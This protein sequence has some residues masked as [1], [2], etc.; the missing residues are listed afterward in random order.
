MSKLSAKWLPDIDLVLP[1]VSIVKE[2]W[3]KEKVEQLVST[4]ATST[5]A[6]AF[7][8]MERPGQP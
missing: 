6:A 1:I 2:E 4:L 5:T 8:V 3:T 7:S